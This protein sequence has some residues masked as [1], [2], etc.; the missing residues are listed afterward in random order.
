[1]IV[2]DAV[3]RERREHPQTATLTPLKRLGNLTGIRVMA[4]DDEEDALELLRV[5]LQAA[6]AEVFTSSS[7]SDALQRLGEITPDVIVVDL[8]MPQ[9]DGLDLIARI[10][11]SSDA[12]IRDVPAAALTAFARSEDRTKAARTWL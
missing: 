8:G 10:R 4:V 9:L 2:H 3:A 11:A 1:M 12:G 7:G 5:V 6:G